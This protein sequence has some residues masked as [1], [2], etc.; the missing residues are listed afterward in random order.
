LLT[1]VSSQEFNLLD[2]DL[3]FLDSIFDEPMIEN[4]EQEEQYKKTGY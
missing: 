2:I 1:S 4:P 3:D